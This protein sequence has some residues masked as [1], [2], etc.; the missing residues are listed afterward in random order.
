MSNKYNKQW[1]IEYDDTFTLDKDL[2]MLYQSVEEEWKQ[3]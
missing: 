1:I 2:Q 3:Y